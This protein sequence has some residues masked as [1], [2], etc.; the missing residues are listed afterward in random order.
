MLGR[1]K[2]KRFRVIRDMLG[3]RQPTVGVVFYDKEDLLGGEGQNKDLQNS[4]QTKDGTTKI[5]T[6]KTQ[7]KEKTVFSIYQNSKMKI[8]P[9][10]D[11]SVKFG[12]SVFCP[13]VFRPTCF[14]LTRF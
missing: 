2:S 8:V 11:H 10:F 9:C 7:S 12:M 3:I 13:P 5:G 14:S 1:K 6:N 4:E